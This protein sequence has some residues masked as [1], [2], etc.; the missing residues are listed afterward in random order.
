MPQKRKQKGKGRPLSV[1]SLDNNPRYE[2]PDPVQL[3]TPA[4]T[5]QVKL[6]LRFNINGSVY[7]AEGGRLVRA[8]V[9]VRK[10][11]LEEVEAEESAQSSC[12]EGTSGPWVEKGNPVGFLD[13]EDEELIDR[14]AV[15]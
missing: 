13:S 11:E 4:A 10:V 14:W 15:E 8:K 5:P 2:T 6:P 12:E 9:G 7:S 1:P 3:P